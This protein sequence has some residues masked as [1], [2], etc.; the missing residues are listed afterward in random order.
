[1]KDL[2]KKT[3]KELHRMSNELKR[4]LRSI[5]FGGAGSKARNVKEY[6]NTRRDRARILTEINKRK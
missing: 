2:K 5:R 3:E 4:V 6:Q 1:M